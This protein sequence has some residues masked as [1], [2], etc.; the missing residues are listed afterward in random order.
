V[1]VASPA[2]GPGRAP[3]TTPVAPDR[4]CPRFPGSSLAGGPG[5]GG[6]FCAEVLLRPPA[7]S[8]PDR[9]GARPGPLSKKKPLGSRSR[10][11]CLKDGRKWLAPAAVLPLQPR[12]AS[13]GSERL[14]PR[15]RPSPP[16]TTPRTKP[17]P[18]SGNRRTRT[19]HR[20][21]G[22]GRDSLSSAAKPTMTQSG[23]TANDI[24]SAGGAADRPDR[25]VQ[26]REQHACLGRA[27]ANIALVGSRRAT[28]QLWGVRR[29][30]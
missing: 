20:H 22:K 5:Q 23:W 3:R 27:A 13:S 24:S 18:S 19:G 6:P 21:G 10:P 30:R 9:W 2:W 4:P 15:R 17:N 14:R 16:G 8:K 25:R 29:G 28:N 26:P 11:P 7:Q 1:P 12:P